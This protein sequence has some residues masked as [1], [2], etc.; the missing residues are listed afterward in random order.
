MNLYTHERIF[1]LCQFQ[2]RFLRIAQKEKDPLENQER[3]G[4]AMLKMMR[5]K[6]VLEAAEK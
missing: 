4:C 3:D 2:P 6:W 1:L 5:R